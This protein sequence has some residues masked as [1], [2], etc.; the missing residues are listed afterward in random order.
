MTAD[1]QKV[2]SYI[3]KAIDRIIA[4]P[5]NTD[6]QRGYFQAL[7]DIYRDAMGRND[8]RLNAALRSRVP[9]PPMTGT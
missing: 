7:I 3:E 1:D 2:A 8:E 5:P 9:L 4:G 6:F